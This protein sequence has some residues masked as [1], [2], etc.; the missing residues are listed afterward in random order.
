MEWV[1]ACFLGFLVA[2][3]VWWDQQRVKGQVA[4][5]ATEGKDQPFPAVPYK[6]A[7]KRGAGDGG[8]GGAAN[9]G[10][11]GGDGGC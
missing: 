11:G 5:N 6:A 10:D 7:D 4:Q 3:F 2:A 1:A 8:G 9:C